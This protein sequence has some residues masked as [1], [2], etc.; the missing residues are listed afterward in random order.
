ME[1]P[2]ARL[3]Q[4]PNTRSQTARLIGT[5]FV[6]AV[7]VVAIWA[8]L[9]GLA[10]QIIQSVPKLIEAKIVQTPPP[11]EKPPPPVPEVK[12]QAP[13]KIV[14][15]YIPPPDI[16]V[17]SPPPSAPIQVQRTTPPP[18]VT[19][20]QPAPITPPAPPPPAA[21]AVPDSGPVG[22]AST[23]T[24]PPYPPVAVR[25]GKEGTATLSVSVSASGNV[26]DATL[27]SSSGDDELD[28]AAIQWGKEHWRDK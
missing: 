18:Q 1:N 7:H 22:V 13:P 25:L 6:G 24:I 5:A 11:K 26:T 10:G 20:P 15:A 16:K 9:T 12:L 14:Q 2:G 28:K 23:H 17:A 8:L 21:P 4:I 27:V 3:H 19:P